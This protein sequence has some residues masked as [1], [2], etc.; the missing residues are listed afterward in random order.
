M[1]VMQKGDVYQSFAKREIIVKPVQGFVGHRNI[2]FA[3]SSRWAVLI[4]PIWGS[5]GRRRVGEPTW[6]LLH[7]NEIR[8]QW[9]R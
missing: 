4:I 9:N 2:G 1:A 7:D 3:S 6:L 5:L 8:C